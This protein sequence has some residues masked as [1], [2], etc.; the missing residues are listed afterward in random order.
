MLFGFG[1]FVG[2]KL[3]NIKSFFDFGDNLNGV[4]SI[5]F[6]FTLEGEP[7]CEPQAALYNED[8]TFYTILQL[9]EKCSVS[10]S[11]KEYE[12]G[13]YFLDLTQ[14]FNFEYGGVETVKTRW[15]FHLSN[16]MLMDDEATI[17]YD[18]KPASW[19]YEGNVFRVTKSCLDTGRCR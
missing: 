2:T 13:L 15:V 9:D 1:I 8:N 7:F 3:N 14:P 6:E 19:S 16:D 11:N 5:T 18:Y 12:Q 4:E 10:I 17:S